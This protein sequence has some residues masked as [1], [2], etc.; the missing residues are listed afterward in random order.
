MVDSLFELVQTLKSGPTGKGTEEQDAEAAR[1][2]RLLWMDSSEEHEDRAVATERKKQEILDRMK[3]IREKKATRQKRK[4]SKED[5]RGHER[6]DEN[7]EGE[8]FSMD[9]L[10][11][12][13]D[14][15]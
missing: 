1:L 2:K 12:G 10:F 13:E 7:S 14:N 15:S 4:D 3:R 6:D 5:G 9:T 8:E 11:E